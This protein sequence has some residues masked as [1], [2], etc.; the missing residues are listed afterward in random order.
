[1]SQ[2][3]VDVCI[4]GG[5]PAGAMLGLLLAQNSKLEVMVL[6]QH[7]AF[8]R[9]FRGESI[10]QGTVAIMEKMGILDKLKEHGFLQLEGLAMYDK[11]EKIF[12]V[13][14][15]D[16][17]AEHKFT[18]DIPQPVLIGAILEKAQEFPNFRLQL[19]A[20]CIE[21][22]EQ[23]DQITGV[24]YR[25]KSGEKFSVSS[26]VVVDASGRYS[27]IRSKAGLQAKIE[28]F[29]R[30]AVWFRLPRPSNWE[31]TTRIKVDGRHHLI[32]LPTYPDTLRI[33]MNI[34]KG[35]YKELRKKPIETFHDHVCKLE[36]ELEGIV[37][38]NIRSWSD[39][40]L[41][42]IFTAEVPQW[43]R[44]GLVLIGDS[45]HT[46]SPILGQGVNLAMQDAYVLAPVIQN[47]L[48]VQPQTVIPQHVF[49][50]YESNRKELISFVQNFQADQERDLMAETEEGME[51]RRIKMSTL[52]QSPMKIE[53]ATKMAYGIF[54][55]HAVNA[56]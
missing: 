11:G 28:D 47:Y 5:G 17:A 35:E 29:K 34:A 21:L 19:G 37:Q 56:G 12:S 7:Q 41:L 20:S 48:E 42:D 6:E 8:Q 53:L 31:L 30:D 38:E 46:V 24:V 44:D 18:I 25:E 54:M 22:T 36:P 51:N 14:F 1:M 39:T 15:H 10:S 33:G 52:N 2:I 55:E 32:I 23:D 3:N 40:V 45:A 16:F 26:S 13:N 4:V 49:D 43:S 27:K 50:Q 9:E